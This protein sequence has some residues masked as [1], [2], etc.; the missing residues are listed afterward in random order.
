[1]SPH[2]GRGLDTESF[3]AKLYAA[4]EDGKESF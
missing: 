4:A 3:K 2:Y 1:M